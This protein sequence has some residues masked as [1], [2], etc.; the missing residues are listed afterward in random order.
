MFSHLNAIIGVAALFALFSLLVT[1][2]V[3]VLRTVLR[4]RNRFLVE[5]LLR[6]FGELKDPERFAAAFLTHPS[7]EGSRGSSLHAILTDPN[8]EQSHPDVR[9]SIATVLGGDRRRLWAWP[10]TKRS[11]IDKQTI[12][13]IGQTVYEKIGPLVDYAI[14]EI[15]GGA[16]TVPAFGWAPDVDAHLR[17]TEAESRSVRVFRGKMW[18][19]ATAAFPEAEGKAPPLKTYVAAF[20]DEAQATASDGFTLLM[21][22]TTVVVATVVTVLFGLDA[23]RIWNDF[24]KVPSAEVLSFARAVQDAGQKML[25]QSKQNKEE[26]VPEKAPTSTDQQKTAPHRSDTSASP[27]AQEK[28]Q[29]G[30]AVATIPS[31]A[32]TSPPPGTTTRAAEL[33]KDT[34]ARKDLGAGTVES[35]AKL[36]EDGQKN[37]EN[38]IADSAKVM[39]IAATA[40]I[41]ICFLGEP[42]Y[43]ETKKSN[44]KG[45][46]DAKKTKDARKTKDD[47]GC[48]APSIPGLIVAAVA[49]SLGAP[50]WFEVLKR[51]IDLKS[52]LEPEQKK[53]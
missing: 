12:K 31:M 6:L 42:L 19:L 39:R 24:E 8:R 5:S 7:L 49:L 27:L 29:T 23:V 26:T 25:A 13:D 47:D 2:I 20:F 52:A 45:F 32:T 37:L 14:E 50:F 35:G 46:R 18:A 11:A 15:V 3:Q 4:M 36:S 43:G 17:T 21:R 30:A 40:P 48:P 10:W 51:A 53:K 22:A 1:S 34:D 41:R 44:M 9:R 33:K 28:R 38:L 16:G